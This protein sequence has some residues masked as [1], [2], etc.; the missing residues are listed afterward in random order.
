MD[1]VSAH[2]TT[3]LDLSTLHYDTKHVLA[4]RRA[5]LLRA[6]VL[7]GLLVGTAA[8]QVAAQPAGTTG[9][10]PADTQSTT[11]AGPAS[12][13]PQPTPPQAPAVAVPQAATPSPASNPRSE[14]DWAAMTGA[15]VSVL[16]A[17]GT[18]VIALIKERALERSKADHQRALE[19]L[20]NEL[21]GQ[22]EGRKTELQTGL[23]ERKS[24][25]QTGLEV[26]KSELQG[27]L[28]V[29]KSELQGELEAKKFDFQK[30]LEQYK[31]SITDELAAHN[32]RRSYEYD[33][34]RRLYAQVEPLLFQLFEAAEGGFRAVTSLVRTQQRGNLPGWLDVEGYYLRSTIHRLFRPLAIFRLMQRTTTLVDFNLD[35]SIRLR[36]TVLKECYRTLTDDFGIAEL[37]PGLPYHPNRADWATA[38][39]EA[40]E[41]NWRQGLVVGLLD[42]LTDGMAVARGAAQDVMNYGEF[43]T[44]TVEGGSLRLA[45]MPVQD[46]FL[47]FD[48]VHRPVLARLLLVYAIL[49]HTFMSI[50]GRPSDHV[51]F[52]AIVAELLNE[53]ENRERLRWWKDPGTAHFDVVRP[54]VDRRLQQAITKGV[55]VK[56]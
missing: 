12:S 10:A 8:A 37:K 26:R 17:I 55:Y 22:L 53:A 54:Y 38:R 2:A 31:G 40:P 16:G 13:T 39:L 24:E 20:K 15:A 33:A 41:E 30:D 28:E 36:Y 6:M 32:A 14:W 3:I 4:H 50:Y 23:E 9:A 49:I 46:I 18:A 7:T 1:D 45:Y 44:A 48:F 43:E 11:P 35:P 47:N 56:F 51:D 52:S 34:R 25:L 42:R 21:Q 5:G 27:G 29:R 19:K